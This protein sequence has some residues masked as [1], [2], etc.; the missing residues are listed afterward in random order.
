MIG[1][2]CVRAPDP[3]LVFPRLKALIF[4]LDGTMYRQDVLRQAMIWRIVRAYL[5][6]PL[7]GYRT[8]RVLRAYRHAQEMLRRDG[9]MGSPQVQQVRLAA[10][11]CR[12]PESEVQSCVEL[13][14]EQAVGLLPSALRPGLVEL[15][16]LAREKGLSLGVLSDYPAE[17][18]LS[19]MGLRKYF[20]VVVTAEDP[21][22]Q[23]FK[24]SSRGLEIILRRLGLRKDQ[25]V[26]VGD[27]ADV[28]AVAAASAGI[29]C[30][31]LTSSYDG[32]R[33]WL[34]ISCF[35]ELSNAIRAR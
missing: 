29:P 10:Q 5:R 9:R 18:K 17:A 11:I 6:H 22:V 28:D 14:T 12:L 34:K 31:I 19:S 15:L 2:R 3:S 20:D 35:E 25:V 26:Y 32:P 1:F 13:W 30:A 24:P 27:R 21:E 4:D 8:V 23:C 16:K 33:Y 7:R